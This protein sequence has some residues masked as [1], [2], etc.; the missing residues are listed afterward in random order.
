MYSESWFYV[1]LAFVICVFFVLFV[2]FVPFVVVQNLRTCSA[3]S[4]P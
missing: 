3:P 2:L 1:S 4:L